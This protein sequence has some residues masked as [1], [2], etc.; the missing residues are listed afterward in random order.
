MTKRQ[1]RVIN[2]FI[3]VVKSGECSYSSAVKEMED[4][5]SYG[6]LTEEAKEV[7]YSEFEN[8]EIEEM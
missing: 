3:N 6:Y 8:E 2:A 7:F 1:K 5:K 4:E